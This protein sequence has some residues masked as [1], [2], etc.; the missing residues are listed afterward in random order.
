M[1][2]NENQSES[3]FLRRLTKAVAWAS[4]WAALFTFI[5]M[6]ALESDRCFEITSGKLLVRTVATLACAWFFLFFI[7]TNLWRMAFVAISILFVLAQPRV[8]RFQATPAEAAV[9]ATVQGLSH[10][11]EMY[12]SQHPK[13][14]Y[15]RDL[16]AF[17]SG[18]YSIGQY[19]MFQYS[20]SR[21][22]LDGPIDGFAIQVTPVWRQC[23]FHRSFTAVNG[24]RIYYTL[25]D[26]VATTMDKLL[27]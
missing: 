25:D 1:V 17:P 6:R 18:N 26:R 2:A 15:P 20:T 3:H 4:I 9:I 22:Q 8:I 24:G 16:P 19:F 27:P 14:G 11:I 21:T 7:L 23:G 5:L 10:D 13:E 12:R